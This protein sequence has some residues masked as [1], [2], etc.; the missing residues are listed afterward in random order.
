MCRY[1]RETMTEQTPNPIR[2]L[3][4]SNLEG[5]ITKIEV[6]EPLYLVWFGEETKPKIIGI[7]RLVRIEIKT[8]EGTT[9]RTFVEE[10]VRLVKEGVE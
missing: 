9:T 4:F 6:T 1:T 3:E 5:K 10:F 8:E 2:L 7:G